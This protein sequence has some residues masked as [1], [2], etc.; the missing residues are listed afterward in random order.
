MD[1]I[2]WQHEKY[3]GDQLIE[4]LNARNG[5]KFAFC[6]RGGEAP[7]LVYHDGKAVRASPFH[8]AEVALPSARPLPSHPLV[9][10]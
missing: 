9:G 1:A 8:H 4:W 6:G 5:W 2:Q 10:A 7:D 3:V